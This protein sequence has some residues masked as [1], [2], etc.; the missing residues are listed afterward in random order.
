[1]WADERP[2]V[3]RSGADRT[4]PQPPGNRAILSNQDKNETTIWTKI[5]VQMH[6]RGPLRLNRVPDPR[7]LAVFTPPRDFRRWSSLG[8][9]DHES[10]SFSVFGR[11]VYVRVGVRKL[12]TGQSQWAGCGR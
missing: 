5:A 4:K 12:V 2:D 9:T 1:M 8:V 10:S 3:G 11:C 6:D 7:S